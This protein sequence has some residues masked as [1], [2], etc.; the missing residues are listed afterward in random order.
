MQEKQVG[1]QG[2]N[3]NY[4]IAGEGKPL[5]ILH[6]WGS[7]SD[8]W[9]DVQNFLSLKGFQVV[10][11][12][13]PGFGK[14]PPPKEVWGIEEYAGFLNA[15]VAAMGFEKFILAGHSI[16]GQIAVQFALDYPEKLRKLV[17]IAAAAVRRKPSLRLRF[18]TYTAKMLWLLV[19][20]APINVK[21]NLRNIGY[22]AIRRSDYRKAEGIMQDVFQRVIRQDLS[23]VLRSVAI[24][25]V[26]LWGSDD[27]ITPLRDGKF[28]A[29][30]IP[31]AK[32]EII[33]GSGHNIYVDK[34]EELKQ[35]MKDILSHE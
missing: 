26:V 30:E 27:K 7:S 3:V 34:P 11:P 2:L 9:A 8:K 25:T 1:V 6:G 20:F 16:G 14:T 5:L 10:V 13:L 22:K 31:S 19:Y 32:L 24:P 21:T 17:L 33:P 29:R 28:I 12:D 35:A 4:K 18:T 23:G 15:F